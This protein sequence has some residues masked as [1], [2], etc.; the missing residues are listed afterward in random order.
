MLDALRRVA[1][2]D[3]TYSGMQTLMVTLDPADNYQSTI[4]IQMWFSSAAFQH[5][6]QHLGDAGNDLF[7]AMSNAD[8]LWFG[9][10]SFSSVFFTSPPFNT[11]G[12]P[13]STFTSV[14]GVSGGYFLPRAV[15]FNQ[16]VGEHESINHCD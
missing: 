15:D 5:H 9:D 1:E 14:N 11:P 7:G 6:V 16:G 10:D 3:E 2:A 12:M 4:E 13:T 8:V